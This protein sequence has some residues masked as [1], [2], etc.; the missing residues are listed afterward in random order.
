VHGVVGNKAAIFPLQ[1]H[2]FDVDP[3]N[4]VQLSNHT[5]YKHFKG[6][7]LSGAE[8]DDLFEGLNA[9]DLLSQCTHLLTGY[10]G[11]ATFV[12]SLA[13]HVQ[14]LRSKQPS[15]R[16]VCDPVMGDAGRLY[17]PQE[18]VQLYHDLLVP[19]ADLLTPN[20]TEAEML[21]SSSIQ[22]L[23][24]AVQ[25][26]DK[27]HAMGPRQV[28]I[29]SFHVNSVADLAPRAADVAYAKTNTVVDSRLDSFENDTEAVADEL[30]VL[31]SERDVNG[32]TK[33]KMFSVRKLP[34]YYT[35]TGDLMAAL[36]LAFSQT[37]TLFS[38]VQNT[39]LSFV[40][41]FFCL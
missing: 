22:T 13:A 10:L 18:F 12:R 25:V 37:Q 5:G 33:R 6:Q 29:T 38:A 21:T 14:K 34:G 30:F 35:G 20:Q 41:S 15:L 32:E 8:L 2:G 28:V 11:S 36:L 4:S 31:C 27:L 16:Y 40:R 24:D 19:L 39:Y 9:N 26:C 3:I 1:L 7:K 23:D 17:V